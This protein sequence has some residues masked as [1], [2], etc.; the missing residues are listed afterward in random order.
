MAEPPPSPTSSSVISDPIS[1]PISEEPRTSAQERRKLSHVWEHFRFDID[2]NKSTCTV[3]KLG[4][5]EICGK[6]IPGKF[7]TNLKNHLRSTHPQEFAA[8]LQKEASDKKE[9]AA[10]ESRNDNRH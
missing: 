9:K 6:L 4:G 8:I 5:Q 3:K 10:K 7:P 1:D 2:T